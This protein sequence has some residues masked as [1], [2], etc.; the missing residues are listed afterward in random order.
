MPMTDIHYYES[1][2]DTE[3]LYI[4]MVRPRYEIKKHT[5]L[6]SKVET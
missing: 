2:T 4:E 1:Q 3:E 5:S 6:E